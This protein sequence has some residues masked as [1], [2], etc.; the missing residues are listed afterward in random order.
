MKNKLKK[1]EYLLYFLVV[2]FFCLFAY[3]LKVENNAGCWT[4]GALLTL[5]L[6]GVIY[7]HDLN[8]EQ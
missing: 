5:S 3:F 4:F 7:V 1:I 6:I 2:A 8:K